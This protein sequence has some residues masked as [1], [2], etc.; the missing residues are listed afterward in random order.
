[1]HMVWA[2][3]KRVAQCKAGTNNNPG[4]QKRDCRLGLA[5][6]GAII[7]IFTMANSELFAQVPS[8]V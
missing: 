7:F 5:T 8:G 6:H 3:L 4:M 2:A 1:M